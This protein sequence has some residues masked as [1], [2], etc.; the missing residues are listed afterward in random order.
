MNRNGDGAGPRQDPYKEVKAYINKIEHYVDD[1]KKIANRKKPLI[2]LEAIKRGLADYVLEHSQSKEYRNKLENVIM[3][4]QGMKQSIK[5]GETDYAYDRIFGGCLEESTT[6]V[7]VEEPHMEKEFQVA[8]LVHFVEFVIRA[9]RDGRCNIRSV[10]L[11]TC[12][13]SEKTEKAFA[14]L[15][16]SAL[17]Y[18]IALGKEHVL[19]TFLAKK[20]GMHDRHIRFLDDSDYGWSVSL[21]IGLHIFAWTDYSSV[22]AYDF[23]RR[24]AWN[25]FELHY[26][27]E[28]FAMRQSGMPPLAATAANR[29]ASDALPP[30][31]SDVSAS[32]HH[33]SNESPPLVTQRKSKGVDDPFVVILP[34]VQSID[35]TQPPPGFNLESAKSSLVRGTLS[36]TSVNGSVLNGTAL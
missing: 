28:H 20:K 22:G 24:V 8:N 2:D 1:L 13:T 35:F 30:S 18:D 16:E 26:H 6:K 3:P 33:V 7:I 15:K 27:R 36:P 29:T 17:R 31:D 12:E 25:D 23:S 10:L 11:R 9:N 34:R 19:P 5:A 4:T 14:T 32:S 21:S